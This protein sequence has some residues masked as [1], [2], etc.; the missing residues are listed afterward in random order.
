MFRATVK[1]AFG[2]FTT[3]TEISL[4]ST[5]S[6]IIEHLQTCIKSNFNVEPDADVQIIS[7]NDMR[8]CEMSSELSYNSVLT[9]LN[10]MVFYARIIRKINNIEYIKTDDRGQVSYLEKQE[11]ERMV[12][13]QISHLRYLSE[14]EIPNTF[15][16]PSPVSE[17]EISRE[18]VLCQ[19]NHV[20]DEQMFQCTH[21]FC[22]EC[23]SSWRTNASRYNCP[24]CRS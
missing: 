5:T 14:A 3:F 21:L 4:N 8:Y 17:P 20:I 1:L 9:P 15:S 7:Q 11:V 23:L 6:Q 10:D 12:N 2:Y 13:G 24:L 18:C 19:E 16:T 22:S